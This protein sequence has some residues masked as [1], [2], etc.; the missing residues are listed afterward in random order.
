MLSGPFRP[1]RFPL[2]QLSLCSPSVHTIVMPLRRSN[3]RAHFTHVLDVPRASSRILRDGDPASITRFRCHRHRLR[4]SVGSADWCPVHPGSRPTWR[5]G[6]MPWSRFRRP[7]NTTIVT[8]R[9]DMRVFFGDNSS[10]EPRDET[11]VGAFT[12]RVAACLVETASPFVMPGPG[13]AITES[14]S[15]SLSSTSTRTPS[16]SP[17][18]IRVRT[19]RPSTMR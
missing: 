2:P 6:T 14:P 3:P 15:F 17:I 18:L 19:A 4:P 1:R 11:Q 16:S 12:F 9:F 7:F 10:P 13:S 8:L 5:G